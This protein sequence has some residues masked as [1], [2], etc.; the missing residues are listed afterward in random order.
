MSESFDLESNN[1][2][3]ELSEDL[4][5]LDIP[6]DTEYSKEVKAEKKFEP[7]DD[8]EDK[9]MLIDDEEPKSDVDK[10]NDKSDNKK[11]P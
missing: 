7:D 5:N 4:S 2:N 6:K 11:N 1:E 3:A 9:N 8:L 10:K